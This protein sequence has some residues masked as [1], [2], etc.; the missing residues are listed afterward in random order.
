MQKTCTITGQPFTV[1]E[2]DLAFYEKMGVPVP[3]ICPQQRQFQRIQFRNFHTLY[4]RKSDMSGKTI[5]SMYHADSPFKVYNS[6]EWW[7]DSW[8]PLEYGQ[9][10]DF[11]RP[12]FEQFAEVLQAVP[13]SALFQYRCE[14]S[15]FANVAM[16]SKNCYLI[17]GCIQNENCMFGHIV[18]KSFQCLD[19]L[20]IYNCNWCYECF[21]CVNCYQAFYS[22]ECTNS[23][24]IY[25]SYNLQNCKNCFG[26]TGL[27][28]KEWYWFNENV[29]KE[30]YQRRLAE[31][32]PLSHKTID[33]AKSELANLKLKTVEPDLFGTQNETVTGNHI[34]FSRNTHDC[35]DI[36]KCE[37]S[38]YL[39]TGEGFKDCHD[40]SFS[41]GQGE[42]MYNSLAV[43]GKAHRVIA[44]QMVIDCH[45][46]SY[47]DN[48]FNSSNLF[49]CVGLKRKEYC[50][51]N[52][53]YSKEEYEILVPKIIEHMKSTGEWGEYPP[54]ELSP[55][56]YNETVAY[57][58]RP[59][60]KEE[61]LSRGLRWRD[62]HQSD[63]YIGPKI[64]VPESFSEV[65]ESICHKIL[66]C[67][68]TGEL[69][70]ITP[71]EFQFYKRMKL[72]IP[73]RTPKRR[74]MDRIAAR[75]PRQ[76]WDRKCGK[77]QKEIQSSHHPEDP[78]T[79]CCQDCYLKE[80]Y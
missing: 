80:L 74:L 7:G 52:K 65:D 51:L 29:G 9:D 48:C 55:F 19:G 25:F 4:N 35:F 26:C 38:R 31:K 62:T 54:V 17:G 36:K 39:Y 28:N 18:W 61:V 22:N 5:V 37:D 24:D 46:L 58:Y 32:L 14:N 64:E 16:D 42:L 41:P 34:Y 1:T 53:H 77:C 75:N 78:R 3:S 47:S 8:D 40:I 10:F 50:I 67:E 73:K 72:P 68:V 66:T 79:V 56:A 27:R 12:F 71:Q 30:E 57:E 45:E 59:M 2:Q 76:L 60:S 15:D 69:Y 21:D 23:S 44:C 20:Y 13:K 70:K 33:W 49:G 11:S 6:E 63:D 43:G